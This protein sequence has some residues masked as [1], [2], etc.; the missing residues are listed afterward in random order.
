ML[1]LRQFAAKPETVP[2][3]TA[4]YLADLGE[5]RGRSLGPGLALRHL[6]EALPRQAKEPDP[7][8]LSGE[9]IFT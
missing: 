3:T 9:P 8:R 4:W 6:P 2:A 5:A 1:T 7:N